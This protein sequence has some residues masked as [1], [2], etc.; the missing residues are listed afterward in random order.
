MSLGRDVLAFAVVAALLTIIP[1]LD[2]ALVLRAAVTQ[3]RRRAFATALGVNSGILVWGVAAAAG[4]SAL[5]IASTVAYAAVRLA[6]AA[7]LIFLGVRY[8]RDALRHH[9]SAAPYGQNPPA[10]PGSSSLFRD[11]RRGFLTNLANPKV[12]VFYIAVL[13]QFIPSGAPHLLIGLL[14]AMIHNAEGFVWFSVLILGVHGGR[15]WLMTT[16]V[17]RVLNATTGLVLIGF[18]SRLALNQK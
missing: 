4:V 5:L 16:R 10:T 18:A 14:L 9:H 2:T 12:G 15:S 11:W 3:G 6:G 7:Y 13:P 8:L 17:Q 1:G